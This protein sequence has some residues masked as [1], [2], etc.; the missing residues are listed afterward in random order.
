MTRARINNK[1]KKLSSR[2]KFIALNQIKNKC[3]NLTK[4]A[5]KSYYVKSTENQPLTNKRFWNSI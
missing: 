3:G 4:T 2:E 5:T 1:Y